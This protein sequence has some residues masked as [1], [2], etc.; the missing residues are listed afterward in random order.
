MQPPAPRPCPT[1]PIH[2]HGGVVG[3]RRILC[4]G[5]NYAAH[6][7]EMGGDAAKDPPV[8][9][10][11]SPDALLAAD[12]PTVLPYPPATSDLHHE[13]EL[14]VL[15]GAGGADLTPDAARDLV[16]GYA[17]AL[18]M[19]RRDLQAAAKAAR[20][21]WA[22]AKDFDG[23]AVVG[24]VVPAATLG[25]P[26]AGPIA[27]DVNGTARQRGDLAQM[28]WDVPALLAHLSSLG[29]LRAGDLVLTGTPEGVGA[30]VPGDVLRGTFPGLPEL[31]VTIGE[32]GMP[33]A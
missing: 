26:S 24:P 17:L 19:T 33:S 27:L 11:K 3:V 12:G 25:H 32:R 21:P 8:H 1:L 2:G 29:L 15:L 30:V 22:S 13:V 5:R 16:Y 28:I 9:F 6:V 10:T 23:S 4:I 31:V 14:A 20:G 7:A 18:D